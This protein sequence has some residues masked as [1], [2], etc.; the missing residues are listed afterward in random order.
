[1]R[2]VDYI[3]PR[4]FGNRWCEAY[5]ELR[6]REARGSDKPLVLVGNEGHPVLEVRLA[7][8]EAKHRLV[9]TSDEP[10]LP[11][12]K[13]LAPKPAPVTIQGTDDLDALIGYEP[14]ESD[15]ADECAQANPSTS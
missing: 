15:L 5:A 8:E 12:V 7:A 10:S 2:R 14:D 11:P 13:A 4:T 6:A 3:S 9:F 1:M